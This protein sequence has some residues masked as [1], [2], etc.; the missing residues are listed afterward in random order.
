MCSTRSAPVCPKHKGCF[1][2]QADRFAVCFRAKGARQNQT[3]KT[4]AKGIG[5]DLHLLGAAE[6]FYDHQ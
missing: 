4:E 3:G 2:W 1:T 5:S 6:R